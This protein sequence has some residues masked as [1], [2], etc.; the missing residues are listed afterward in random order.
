L[1][2]ILERASPP[3]NKPVQYGPDPHHFAELRFPNGP[4][5]FPFLFVIHGGF[6][7]SAFD[8]THIGH[9]CNAFAHEGI[10]TCNVEYRRVGDPGG[11]WPGTF[12]D[13]SLATDSIIETISSDPRVD[14]SRTAVMGHSAGGHLALWLASRH[15]IPTASPVHGNQRHR[16]TSAVSLAGVCDLR[17]AWKQRLGNGAV[18]RLMGGTPDQHPDRFDAGSP[19]ELLPSGSRQVL[20][21]GM[22][23]DIVPIS[24]SESFVEKAERLGEHLNLVKLEGVGHFELIDPDSNAWSKVTRTVLPVLDV[25]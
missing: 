6:W 13:V 20:I 2:N 11:G 25:Q 24:Q 16:I 5:P 8:L 22:D 3:F 7:K 10:I 18:E 9:L 14:I 19:F 23:D 12:Q 21:H 17:T 1:S 4:G 15:R